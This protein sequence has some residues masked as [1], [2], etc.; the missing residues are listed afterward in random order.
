MKI[1]YIVDD[2][3]KL[4][5]RKCIPGR[6]PNMIPNSHRYIYPRFDSMAELQAAHEEE[7]LE[8]VVKLSKQIW[9]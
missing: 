9:S 4:T 6:Y 7:L 3:G 1:L 5:L 8:P 2:R